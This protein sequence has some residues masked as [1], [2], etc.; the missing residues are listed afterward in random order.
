MSNEAKREVRLSWVSVFVAAVM[1]LATLPGRT[2][3]LG[4]ITEPLL[5]DTGL[6]RVRYADLNLWATL[7]GSVFC[8][9]AGWLLDR[10]G[11]RR[12]TVSILIPLAG[13][14]W[15]MS[16]FNQGAVF[17]FVML[18]LTRALG[19]S[20]LSVAS[21]SAVGKSFGQ[22]VGWANGV[23]AVL[24]SVMFAIAFVAIGAV[25]RDSGWRVAWQSV[26]FALILFVTPL[27]F[28]FLRDSQSSPQPDSRNESTQLTGVP[29]GRALL[30]APF[31][32]FSGAT[33]LFGLVSSGLGL[34]NEAV[35]A[36]RGFDQK[37]YHLFLA[38]TTLFALIG[39]MLCGWL[40]L[41]TKMQ[42]LL[43][44]AMLLYG[45]ALGILPMLKTL[46]QLWGFALLIGVA[47]GFITV[48][49]FAIWAHAFGRLE[50]GRIQGGAQMITVFA[51]A[52][53]PVL[54]AKVHAASG[55]YA[56]A[57]WALT[58]GV[59]L[60]G[61]AAWMTKIRSLQSATNPEIEEMNGIT[62]ASSDRAAY[63]E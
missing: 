36:E 4:L 43:G 49:F 7:L 42:S 27:V 51:S 54:F 17:L 2:Q 62:A 28:F 48:L 12:V 15:L 8:L 37:T 39:Q 10:F 31:W 26:A 20:A 47:A 33:A 13:V 29:F 34:F 59:L 44:V 57:L 1:M 22:R 50:L 38:V 55:S 18:L 23:Y 40:S 16:A 46:P 25:V 35:L 60:F 53:G 21:I 63:S 45:I 61:V 5:R 14:V 24:L 6:D 32:I 58:P 3:G 56:P 52:V 9:P 30:T 41:R 11:A 19:Q